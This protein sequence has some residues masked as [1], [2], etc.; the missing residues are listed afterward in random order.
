M[1]ISFVSRFTGVGG[2][3]LLGVVLLLSTFFVINHVDAASND[4][5]HDGR[6]ITIHDRGTEKVILT[7]ARTVGDALQEA[8]VSVVDEDQVEPKL[9]SQLVATDYTVNIYRARPVIVVDGA[10]R[11]KIMTAAQTPD[12]IANAAG[13]SLQDE[14][15][16]SLAPSKDIVTDG[17]GVVLT[18]NRATSF[19]LNLY[20]TPTAM[21]SRAKT[22]GDML[23]DKQITLAASDTLST[24]KTTP[25]SGGMTVSIWRNGVQTA[26][27]DEAIDFPV[28]KVQDL[29]HPV[30]YHEIQTPGTTGKKTVTYQ[31]TM[32]NGQEVG[33]TVIQSVVTAQPVEQ[34]EVIGAAPPAGSH[35]DWMAQ[36]GIAP[37][38]FGFVTYIVEHEGGWVPCKVQGG[39]ID[40]SYSGGLG[41]G[42]VQS[43]PGS[44]MAS[45]GSDWR[46]N[47]VT[48]LKWATSYAVG[49]Y[50]SWQGAY[51]HWLS[52]HNW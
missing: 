28:R 47:P 11:A 49:R 51:Q 6:L 37:G 32:Q 42:L 25:L 14:D 30:G 27:V 13:L 20:G 1:R 43:T 38:D 41:Y 40:C 9:D 50:G 4:P 17:A 21:R 12:S 19:T 46:T 23:K 45:A 15:S 26:T 10:I 3:L 31:I 36:A 22:V 7:H 18:I 48:Q 5:A 16:A 34:V 35:E 44:K 39:S 52:S 2:L 33:R 29:D 24:D 8:H